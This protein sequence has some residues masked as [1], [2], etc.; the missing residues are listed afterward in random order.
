I[1]TFEHKCDSDIQKAD[2]RIV[3]EFCENANTTVVSSTAIGSE[4]DDD[5]NNNCYSNNNNNTN[6]NNNSKLRV[7]F[8]KMKYTILQFFH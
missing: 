5:N 4:N 6:N 2:D 7:C 8:N 1:V 3:F